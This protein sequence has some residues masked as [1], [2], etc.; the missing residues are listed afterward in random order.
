MLWSAVLR[1]WAREA[2]KE[3]AAAQ[4]AAKLAQ[5]NQHFALRVL[6][7]ARLWCA[8]PKI[9]RSE[10]E[11]LG[12]LSSILIAATSQL[13]YVMTPAG[14]YDSIGVPRHLLSARIRSLGMDALISLERETENGKRAVPAQTIIDRH[15]TI[16]STVRGAVDIPRTTIKDI[17]SDSATLVLKLFDLRTDLEPRFDPQVDAWL[18]TFA[19]DQYHR[20]CEWIGHAL[21]FKSGPICAL[22]IAGPPGAGK[23][24]LIQGLAECINTETFGDEREFGNFQSALLRTPFIVVNEGVPTMRDGQKDIAD[25]FRH[26][27]GGD[28]IT[29]NQK[30]QAP[31]I[32][33]NPA[34]IIFAANNM[35]AV[36]I[37]TGHRDL[38]PEDRDALAIRLMH[39]DIPQ[40]AGDWLRMRGGL[41]YT[42]AFGR[43]WIRGDSGAASDYVVARHFLHLYE[44][45]PPV[46]VGNRLLVEG[47][48]Q[49]DLLRAMSTRSGSAP[50][51]IES[52]VRMIEGGPME[53]LVIDGKTVLVTVDA[54]VSWYRRNATHANPRINHRSASKVFRGLC[55]RGALASPRTV[56]ASGKKKR[57]R[58]YEID[59]KTLLVES[60]ENGF[61]CERLARLV[62]EIEAGV[63]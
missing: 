21:D 46:P 37:L 49:D 1:Y 47:H 2:A 61:A 38:T 20:L 23:K 39:I 26:L 44:Q 10:A 57:A 58:W 12:F 6:E 34:R 4:D 25:T 24:L 33:N 56:E 27:V 31:I 60:I 32:V 43:R 5:D 11:S 35:D 22:S 28:A 30:F 14:H 8:H 16:V 42:G 36:S 9:W 40:S 62:S 63:G 54:V 7:G 55:K 13:C 17:E 3:E 59:V 51:I 19:G 52:L 50:D 48:L 41:S 15:A 29:C 53:G 45:R 18:K